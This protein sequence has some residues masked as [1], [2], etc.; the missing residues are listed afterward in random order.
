MELLAVVRALWRRRFLVA[1]GVILSIAAAVALG[2]APPA[3]SGV[4]WTRV[5]LDTPKSQLVSSAPKAADSLPWRT[6]L[7]IHL[8]DTEQMKQQLATK[9]GVPI[10]QIGVVDSELLSPQ[11]GAS[12]PHKAGEAA[13]I[14]YAPY[15]LTATMPNDSL[16]MIAIEAAA[17]DAA[18]AKKLATAA[19]DVLAAQSS[20]AGTYSSPILTGG[21]NETEGFTISR[22]APLHARTIVT[23][24]L[25]VKGIGA[26]LFLL[27]SWCCAITIL[28]LLAHRVLR[29]RSVQPA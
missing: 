13:A 22:A 10:D 6:N 26:A 27:I 21:V 28:P 24:S 7:L 15:A 1:A 3:S 12:L 18:G 14:S 29:R 25:P 11:V 19:V 23:K 4:A 17:P 5:V 20:Q 9:V 16:P 8:L 2:G